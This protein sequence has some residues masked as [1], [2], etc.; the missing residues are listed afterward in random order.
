M[1]EQVLELT[2]ISKSYS[3]QKIWVPAVSEVNLTIQKAT[4]NAIMG[5]SGCGKSTLLR[6]MGLLEPPNSGKL[7]IMGNQT[8]TLNQS[9]LADLRRKHIGFIFQHNNLIDRLDIISN[10]ALPLIINGVAK[11][12]ARKVAMDALDVVNLVHRASHFPIELS[13]GQQQRTAIARSIVKRPELIFA[14]E[15]TGNLDTNNSTQV[16]ELLSQLKAL[17]STIVMV[18]HSLEDAHYADHLIHMRDGTI[19]SDEQIRCD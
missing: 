10:V 3:T 16:L 14:D 4:F 9:E 2:G 19:E 11:Q 5:P 17:G 18:T 1:T 8:H 12:L 6:M 7:A 13:G 15:P